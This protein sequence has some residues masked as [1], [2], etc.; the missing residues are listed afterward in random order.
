MNIG[1]LLKQV[2]DT[3]S[4]IKI[5]GDANG[6][7][8][9]DIKWIVNPYDEFAVEQAL[10]V[11]SAVGGEV[12]IFSLGSSRTLDAARTA[13]AMGADRAVILDDDGFAGSDSLGVAASLAKAAQEE[14]IELLFAGKQA[15]DDDAVQVPQIVGTLLE[16]PVATAISSYE[17]DGDSVTVKREVGGGQT[18]VIKVTLPAVFTAD[19]GLNSPRYASLPGIMKAKSKP[20]KRYTADDLGV[21]A[22]A[23]NAK[24]TTDG[25]HMPPPRP[26]GRILDGEL[27]DQVKELVKLLRQ[28]AKVL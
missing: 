27:G 2:P 14:G 21:E 22:G 7:E 4:R 25:Y 8:D 19:K 13:L 28:E 18:E 10:Q 16:W 3:E 24:V 5:N 1:V 15:I 11:K 6:I 20:V 23:D 17:Q 9:G 12:V 26:A